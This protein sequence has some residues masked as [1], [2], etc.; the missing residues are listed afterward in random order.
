MRM[1]CM[2]FCEVYKRSSRSSWRISL[3]DGHSCFLPRWREV[4]LQMLQDL[5]P[6]EQEHPLGAGCLSVLPQAAPL[7]N[8]DD[9][10]GAYSRVE[11]PSRHSRVAP[12][13]PRRCCSR[14]TLHRGRSRRSPGGRVP[15]T[16]QRPPQVL[17][18]ALV[19]CRVAGER[20]AHLAHAA[21]QGGQPGGARQQQASRGAVVLDPSGEGPPRAERRRHKLGAEQ[22]DAAGA[23]RVVDAL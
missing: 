4:P 7:V 15:D 22:R 12:P 9:L 13:S 20:V 14:P 10:G 8:P 1:V 23:K 11:P 19:P 6:K 18:E 3:S 17:A 21:L 2:C 16:G 5:A